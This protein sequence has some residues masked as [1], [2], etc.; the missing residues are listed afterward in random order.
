MDSRL[1]SHLPFWSLWN[2][3]DLAAKKL[4]PALRSLHDSK[5][6]PENVAIL[7]IGRRPWDDAS[8][9]ARV[10]EAVVEASDDAAAPDPAFLDRFYYHRMDMWDT[11]AYDELR[12]RADALA[13][14]RD[15][16]DNRIY[17]LATA[18][19]LFPVIA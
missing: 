11:N 13:R 1:F 16:G 18:P 9:R 6:L 5:D 19:D 7:G 3:R 10:A 17:F 8:Y 15:L 12:S 14:A 4:F 2:H